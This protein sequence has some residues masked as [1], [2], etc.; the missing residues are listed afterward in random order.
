[1]PEVIFL[2]A[3]INVIIQRNLN[4]VFT[5]FDLRTFGNIKWV[6]ILIF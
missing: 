2:Q 3:N 5:L 4:P 6:N 1:M